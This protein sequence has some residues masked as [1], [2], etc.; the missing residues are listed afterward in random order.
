MVPRSSWKSIISCRSGL[1]RA[2]LR[3]HRQVVFSQRRTF[4]CR[5][6]DRNGELTFEQLV[7][8]FET[9]STTAQYAHVWAATLSQ[10]AHCMTGNCCVQYLRMALGGEL[11]SNCGAG[12]REPGLLEPVPPVPRLHLGQ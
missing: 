3:F 6:H 8:Y 5:V 4:F 1:A 7:S 9:I 11:E 10:L 2:V 12:G